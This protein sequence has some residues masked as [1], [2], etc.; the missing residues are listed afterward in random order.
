MSNKSKAFFYCIDLPV[1]W[2]PYIQKY[3]LDNCYTYSIR[4]D[5]SGIEQATNGAR[6]RI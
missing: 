1:F 6:E 4:I 5:A 3:C 2:K